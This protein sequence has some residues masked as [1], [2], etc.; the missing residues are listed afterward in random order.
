MTPLLLLAIAAAHAGVHGPWLDDDPIGFDTGA[1]GLAYADPP[2][3]GA[4]SSRTSVQLPPSEDL[5]ER[6]NPVDEW[7]TPYMVDLLTYTAETMAIQLPDADRILIG[8]IGSRYGGPLP[9]HKTHREGIDA[10]VGFYLRGHTQGTAR[11]GFPH[12]TPATL[13][14]EATWLE[15]KTLLD[16]GRVKFILLDQKL[17]DALRVWLLENDLATRTEVDNIFPPRDTPR[18]W[19]HEGYLWHVPLHDDH[20]HVQVKCSSN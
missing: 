16:T 3:C 7:G 1:P 20:M 11:T 18:I 2:A 14:Y 9:P 15:I 17:I 5:Y 10:D 12:A 13:D 6:A 8:D 19:E 4:F